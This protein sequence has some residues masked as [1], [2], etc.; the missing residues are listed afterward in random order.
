MKVSN[1]IG[2]PA[3]LPPVKYHG[4][5]GGPQSRSGSFGEKSLT[6]ARNPAPDFPTRQSEWKK[7]WKRSEWNAINYEYIGC[8]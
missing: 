4:S 7:F 6:P 3:A 5:H 8:L 2:S 1:Q